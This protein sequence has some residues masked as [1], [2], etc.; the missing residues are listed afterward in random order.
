MA[1]IRHLGG[2]AVLLGHSSTGRSA[3]WAAAEEP[4][5]VRGLIL[6]DAFVRDTRPGALGLLAAEVVGRSTTLWTLY[7]R[8]LYPS[9]RPPD[10]DEYLAQLKAKMREPERLTAMRR[11]LTQSAAETR[12]RLGE[13]RCPVLVVMGTRDGDFRDPVREAQMVAQK[14]SPPATVALIQDAGHYPHAELPEPTAVA[15]MTAV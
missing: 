10:F 8:S 12:E 9:A 2:P 3:V 14:L 1:V 5:D 7:Y 13:V 15:I 11:L 4:N 6:V